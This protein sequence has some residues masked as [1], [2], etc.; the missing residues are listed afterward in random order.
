MWLL[1]VNESQKYIYD[2]EGFLKALNSNVYLKNATN[3]YGPNKVE[4]DGDGALVEYYKL[5]INSL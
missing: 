5:A 4:S 1:Y 3:V 2:F